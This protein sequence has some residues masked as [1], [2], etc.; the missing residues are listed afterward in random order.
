MGLKTEV[1]IL[2]NALVNSPNVVLTRY[3]NLA[4]GVTITEGGAAA[5]VYAAAGAGQVQLVAAGL[6]TTGMWICGAGLTVPSV[7]NVVYVLWLGRGTIPAAVQAA[8]L[9]F[10]GVLSAGAAAGVI[11]AM[12]PQDIMLPLPLF[13]TAGVGIA[14]DLATSGNAAETA[15]ATVIVATG[16]GA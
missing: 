13:V 11:T 2:Y 5:W 14:G 16:L 9:D 1:D 6:N 15:Q 7:T 8:E 4:V 10:R 12:V 3:P